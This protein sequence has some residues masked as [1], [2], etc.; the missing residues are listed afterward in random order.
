MRKPFYS[1]RFRR[2]LKR[3]K[4]R[5]KS[6]HKLEYIIQEICRSGDAP[7]ECR[8]HNLSGNWAGYRE[9]HIEPDWLLIY[10]VTDEDVT[11]YRSGT[12]SDLF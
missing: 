10:T 5:G 3:Q 12:H 9:C 7:E 1:T 2:D 4:K 11:F 6:R 8:P